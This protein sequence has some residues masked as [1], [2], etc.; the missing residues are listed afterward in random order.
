MKR[1]PFVTLTLAALAL[2]AHALSLGDS[3]QFARDAFSPA[4]WWTLFTAHLT[5]FD[6]N[7]L[8]W[9]LAVFLILG[10]LGESRSRFDTVAAL[11]F[12]APAITLAVWWFQPQFESYRGL[13]G[14]DSALFGLF[15]ADLV[16]RRDA[17]SR[18][19]GAFGFAAVVAKCVFEI[20]TGTTAF[21]SGV[22]YSPVPLAHLVG[23]IVGAAIGLRRQGSEFRVQ[24]SELP[25]TK[26]HRMRR[27]N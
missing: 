26:P 23:T 24:S 20:K 18:L 15:A 8:A 27:S 5:H 11:A 9:D 3:L 10:W 21:A 13:S 12:A 22:G 2:A 14:L 19:V 4:A 25:R 6:P 1:I 17:G 16:R 7:H